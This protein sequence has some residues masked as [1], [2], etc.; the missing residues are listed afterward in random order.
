[1]T[2]PASASLVAGDI[3]QVSGVGAG[4]WKVAQ[5]DGQ[6]ILFTREIF[7]A[8][9]PPWV[10]R[11]SSRN[12]QSVVSSDDGTKLA[13]ADFAGQIY[14]STNLGVTWTP[15]ESNRDW[16]SVASSAD[17]TKLVAVEISGQI[18]TFFQPIATTTGTAGFI[19]GD[20][21]EAVALQYIGN[22][23]FTVI[24]HEGALTVN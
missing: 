16:R 15:R 1:M 14:T 12:W 6:S 3:V 9:G 7:G 17:G 21:N 20:Q 2:L 24:G 5:N 23:T 19:R 18:Y 8:F 13:A 11:E 22:D 10:P 4:G